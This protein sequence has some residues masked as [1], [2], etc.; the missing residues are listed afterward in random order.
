MTC[1]LFKCCIPYVAFGLKKKDIDTESQA[2]GQDQGDPQA[3]DDQ[4]PNPADQRPHPADQH[5]HSADQHPHPDVQPHKA[6]QTHPADQSRACQQT[7]AVPSEKSSHN[8]D[9]LDDSGI[10]LEGK[11]RTVQDEKKYL[12]SQL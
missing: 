10:N 1:H 7:T 3:T 9:T 6:D 12:K 2:A 5:P 11:T 8:K 4:R